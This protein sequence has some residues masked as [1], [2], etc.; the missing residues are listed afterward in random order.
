M[1]FKTFLMMYRNII[2]LIW[3]AIIL[4]VFKI[5]TNFVFKNGLSILFILLLVVLPVVLYILTTIYKHQLIKKKKRKK[6]RYISRLN[7][8]IENKQ[9]QKNFIMPLEELIG[10]TELKKDAEKIIVDSQNISI[11]FNKYKAQL[12]IK[13]TLVEY[14]FYYSNKLETMNAYDSR[15]YQYHETNHLYFAIIELVKKLTLESLIY[16]VN[17]KKCLLT[18]VNSN[19]ILYQNKNLKKNKIIVKEEISLK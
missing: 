8:D 3:W 11:F 7:E 17:K 18:T 4:V 1:K 9:F 14:N 15:F 12:A 16:E 10:K 19:I 5:T 6:I 2:I 13:N